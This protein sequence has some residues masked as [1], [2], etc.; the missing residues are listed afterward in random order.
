MSEIKR[1][2]ESELE[3]FLTEAKRPAKE[4]LRLHKEYGGKIEIS[5][6]CPVRGYED[7]AYWYSPGVAAPC[8]EIVESPEK[9]WE[10]TNKS[11]TIAVISD[12]SRVL[13]LGDIGPEAGLPVMEGKSLLFK[14]LGGVDAVPIMLDIK[15]TDA[16]IETVLRLQPSF[17]GINLEDIAQPK[18]FYILE[19]LQEK[20]DIPVW[21]DDQQGTATVTLAALMNALKILG[22]RRDEVRIAFIGTGAA[23][24]A[25]ARLIFAWGVDPSK[26]TMVDVNGIL[27]KDRHDFEVGSHQWSL[28]QITNEDGRQGGIAEA[29]KSADVVIAYS[30]PGPGTIQPEWVKEM[31]E[32]SIVFAC[33]N[34]IPEIWPWEAKEAGAAI[35]ATGRSDFPNQVNNSLTFPAIFRGV[36]DVRAKKITDEMCF[37]AANALANFMGKNLSAEQ[38]LP[39]MNNIEIYPLQAVAVAEQ[40]IEQG[41]AG[42]PDQHDTLLI[43][44]RER[45]CRAQE[46]TRILMEK[47][48]IPEDQQ[49]N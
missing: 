12:G 27:N 42:K 38:L 22:K 3:K 49:H 8:L 20:A 1:L 7:F 11:N 29:M 39:K 19:K 14:Y 36:L 46:A 17:G 15:D 43:N 24:V 41:I 5:L 10:L 37:A 25:C 28:C 6:K 33:A 18:C 26:A 2:T 45:I 34:P 4:S 32:D 13:G 16:F 35:I 21:H 31:A 47:G 30:K 23:G 40:A 9:V 48:I 44:A